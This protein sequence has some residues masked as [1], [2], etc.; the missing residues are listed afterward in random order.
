MGVTRFEALQKSL[1]VT[2]HVLTERLRRLVSAGVLEKRLYQ[3]RPPRYDY[4]LTPEGEEL[5]DVL[6]A[7]QSWGRLHMPVRRPAPTDRKPRRS[8]QAAD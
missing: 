4:V 7:L 2:R 5:R 8:A 6:L 1:G 3:Q